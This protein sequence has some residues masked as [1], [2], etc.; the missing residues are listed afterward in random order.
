MLNYFDVA[1]VVMYWSFLQ[2]TGSS[3]F[4]PARTDIVE[5]FVG[6]MS[7]CVGKWTRKDFDL[8]NCVLVW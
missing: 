7:A 6:K 3:S 4:K 2:H 8:L 5:G 1:L